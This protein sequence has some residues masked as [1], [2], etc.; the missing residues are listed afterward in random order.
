MS[1]GAATA[2]CSSWAVD[3]WLSLQAGHWGSAGVGAGA[4][5]C[6]GT[7]QVC[8]FTSQVHSSLQ[9]QQG[10][11][12]VLHETMI[13]IL[14]FSGSQVVPFLA[15][16]RGPCL[17]QNFAFHQLKLPDVRSGTRQA[18]F[19]RSTI[20]LSGSTLLAAHLRHRGA[21][22]PVQPVQPTSSG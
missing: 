17:Q 22:Q 11:E 20:A 15:Q 2:R 21:A 5:K 3:C 9:V 16:G 10:R 1:V 8:R 14:T 7:Q 12:A 19:L 13:P 18:V 4:G 6:S